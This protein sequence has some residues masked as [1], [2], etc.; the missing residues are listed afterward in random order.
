LLPPLPFLSCR[1]SGIE[2]VLFFY[3]RSSKEITW[4]V[5]STTL[6]YLARN[7]SLL[8]APENFDDPSHDQYL[9]RVLE[10]YLEEGAHLDLL[11]LNGVSSQSWVFKT[12][13]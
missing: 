12:K 1:R 13:K 6:I 5:T 3:Q 8:D 2:S 4:L 7:S 10:V 11:D 9:C